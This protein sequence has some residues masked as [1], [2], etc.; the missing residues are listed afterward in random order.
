[1]IKVSI[2]IGLVYLKYSFNHKKIEILFDLLMIF[3]NYSIMARMSLGEVQELLINL[4][5]VKQFYN[6]Q[7]S[8]IS[9]SIRE[10]EKIETKLQSDHIW[11]S[12]DEEDAD[13]SDEK[14][15]RNPKRQKINQK[16]KIKVKK[17]IKN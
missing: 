4:R 6:R 3:T 5:K 10:H 15:N 9:S 13:M 17:N 11:N 7:L 16:I 2:N 14:T 1:M 12:T 8:A